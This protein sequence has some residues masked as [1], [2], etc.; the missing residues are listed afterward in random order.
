MVRIDIESVE[1]IEKIERYLNK[2]KC[3]LSKYEN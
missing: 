2:I 1:S 3:G